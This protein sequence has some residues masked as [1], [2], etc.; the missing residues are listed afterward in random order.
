MLWR[1][2]ALPNRRQQYSNGRGLTPGTQDVT[3]DIAAGK[4]NTL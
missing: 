3:W 1:G 4:R 2:E